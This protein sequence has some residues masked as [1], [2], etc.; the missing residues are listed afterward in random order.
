MCQGGATCLPTD[1]CFCELPLGV[2]SSTKPTSLSSHQ[3]V[4]CYHIIAEKNDQLAFNS[5][6]YDHYLTCYFKNYY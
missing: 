1:S 5:N 4:K 6:S 2:L 3:N